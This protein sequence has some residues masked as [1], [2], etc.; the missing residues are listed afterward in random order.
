LL[1]FW[2]KFN[3]PWWQKKQ[4]AKARK[5]KNW[6]EK[7][8][9]VFVFQI[10]P[11]KTEKLQFNFFSLV[12][13]RDSKHTTSTR[14][15]KTN[16]DQRHNL[17]FVKKKKFDRIFPS[18]PIGPPHPSLSTAASDRNPHIIRQLGPDTRYIQKNIN[19]LKGDSKRWRWKQQA[20]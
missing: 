17:V 11:R 5:Q 19:K 12:F 13:F 20:M 10:F 16:G 15:L 1:R 6:G 18:F 2:K 7:F 3:G 14:P 9:R 8:H 4:N